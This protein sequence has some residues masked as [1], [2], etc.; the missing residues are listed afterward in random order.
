VST[1]QN[2]NIDVQKFLIYFDG[3]VGNL[4]CEIVHSRILCICYNFW[5]TQTVYVCEL[6]DSVCPPLNSNYQKC[7]S[8]YWWRDFRSVDKTKYQG[9]DHTEHYVD[10]ELVC[11]HHHHHHQYVDCILV[12]SIITKI[13]HYIH[14]VR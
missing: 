11:W 13:F 7:T 2:T 5:H 10:L 8:R 14:V 3:L 12:I 1:Y 6:P 4:I 9:I